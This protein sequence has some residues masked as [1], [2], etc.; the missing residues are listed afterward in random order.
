MRVA[1]G[2]SISL[3]PGKRIEFELD[4]MERV[5]Y[6]PSREFPAAPAALRS[7]LDLW[8]NGKAIV[9]IEPE[10]YLVWDNDQKPIPKHT[11]SSWHWD[12]ESQR[13]VPNGLQGEG[14]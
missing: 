12:R 5:V 3:E 4:R 7:S 13:I 1:I 2:P 9:E 8:A 6:Q 14:Q 10:W 11:I